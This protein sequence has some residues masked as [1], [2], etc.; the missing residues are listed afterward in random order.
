MDLSTFIYLASMISM[1]LGIFN[2]LPIPGLDGGQLVFR[3][4][5]LIRRKPVNE[6]VETMINAGM[7]IILLVLSAL[8]AFKDVINIFIE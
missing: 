1:N 2:L 8:I 5:E 4:I 7:I 3:F 6:K